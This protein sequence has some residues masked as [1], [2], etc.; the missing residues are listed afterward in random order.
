MALTNLT[1]DLLAEFREE[2]SLIKEQIEILDPL[3]TSLRMPA[4][5]ELISATILFIAEIACYLLSV[6]AI[7]FLVIAHTVY[8]FTVLHSIYT[9]RE[10]NAKLGASNISNLVLA[11]YA[12]VV[13]LAFIFL[14]LGYMSRKIRQKNAIL[15]QAGTDIKTIL[16]QHLERKAAIDTLDHRHMLITTDMIAPTAKKKLTHQQI[17][18]LQFDEDEEDE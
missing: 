1:E 14:L 9:T 11:G 2:S 10:I 13:G 17:S 5:Q 6:G 8:P 3:G 12:V 7:G 18:K 4:A 16:G 15:Q